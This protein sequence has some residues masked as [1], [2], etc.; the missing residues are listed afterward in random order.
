MELISTLIYGYCARIVSLALLSLSVL[1]LTKTR[2]KPAFANSLAMAYPIPSEPPVTNAQPPSYLFLR[3]SLLRKKEAKTV[4][5]KQNI[6]IVPIAKKTI[7][8][9]DSQGKVISYS[10]EAFIKLIGSLCW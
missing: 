4:A 3:S 6:L 2:L 10:I 8:V 7:A 9:I 1:R 5:R